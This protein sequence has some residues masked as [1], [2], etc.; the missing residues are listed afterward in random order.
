[1]PLYKSMVCL[2]HENCVQLCSPHPQKVLV[3][4]EEDS[5]IF[6]GMKWHLYKAAKILQADKERMYKIICAWREWMGINC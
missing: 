4:Q 3:A 1:M 2:Y 6:Q 5:R